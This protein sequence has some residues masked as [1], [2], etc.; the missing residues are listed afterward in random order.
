MK[1]CKNQKGFTLI[2]IIT[3]IAIIAIL[4]AVVAPRFV[5]RT[6]DAR[7]SAAKADISAIE[8]AL[9]AYEAD[10]GAYPATEQGFEAL[11]EIPNI[12]PIPANWKG[13][14]LKKKAPKDPWGNPY[15]FVSPGINNPGSYDI[16][17]LGKDGKEGGIGPDADITNWTQE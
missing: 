17:S 7:I 13:P 4:A 6:E 2:E 11:S 10:N 5:G 8:T 15:V 16:Y 12:P 9:D 1:N 3:V 14:Y